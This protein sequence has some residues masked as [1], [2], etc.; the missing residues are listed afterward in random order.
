M[1]RLLFGVL[2]T[3]SLWVLTNIY[4]VKAQTQIV[5]QS[6]IEESKL[7]YTYEGKKIPLKQRNDVVGVVFKQN[8]TQSTSLPLH[9]QLQ[10]DLR[11]NRKLSKVEIKS[12]GRSYALMKVA[13]N[14]KKFA[15]I[16]LRLNQ[17]DYIDT[18]LPVLSRY[19]HREEII[20]PNEI[21]VTFE[22]QL[23]PKQ[24]LVILQQNSLE[25]VRTSRL[26]T[27]RYIVKSKIASGTDIL[28]I[29]NQ[30]YQIKG[31]KSATPNFIQLGNQEISRKTKESVNRFKKKS[32]TEINTAF[33]SNLLPQQWYL[34]STPLKFCLANF[35]ESVD[36]CLT[37]SMYKKSDLS[38]LRTDIY[39]TE[40]WQNSNAGKGV[41]VAVLD[42]LIQWDHP[43]LIKNVYTI[44]K[45]EKSKFN[46]EKHGWDFV[47]DDA[48]TRI[49]Q[50][51]LSKF[52]PLFQDTFW[53][54]DDALLEK[55]R[56]YVLKEN[57]YESFCIRKKIQHFCT[58][59]QIAEKI[60][61]YIRSEIT[62]LFHGTLVSGVIAAKPQESKGLF[63]VAPH[64]KILPVN[65]GKIVY[66]SED[67]FRESIQTSD[68]VEGIDY[69]V[70]R[71][72]DIVN[73]S[74]G[75]FLPTAE[76][77]NAIIRAYN[78]NPSIVFVG[79]AS[80]D[81]HIEVDFPAAIKGVIAVGATNINGYR[82]PYSNFGNGLTVVAPGGDLSME[83]I[84]YRGGI[85]T[86]G[87]TGI[88]KFW[89]T[90][91]FKPKTPW[92]STLDT[93]GKYIRVQ[94]TSFASPIVAGVIAL[95]K[96]EDPQRRLSRQQIISILK[97]T[98]SYEGLNLSEE[99][100]KRYE[101]LVLSSKVPPGISIEKY[102]FGH[103]LVN[104][105]KAVKEVQR[106]LKN[107]DNSNTSD[108]KNSS[109]VDTG[110]E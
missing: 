22:E 13:S 48:D 92:G 86:T 42:F 85:L 10:Q 32:L 97:Q 49:S 56:H 59:K 58:R 3:S 100:K 74:L 91:I 63:G 43:D 62:G 51:A 24:K 26:N 68:V 110:K 71:G 19:K 33:Q 34:N 47:N 37:Q 23:S 94:G 83:K 8:A 77:K 36:K 53:L 107:L 1:K 29:A 73:I 16:Q 103:G 104:A 57:N 5:K 52:R 54:S 72:A 27:N 76:F 95:M 4:P 93:K 11:R 50:K 60:R 66:H 41:V 98:S 99:E 2:F 25:I 45:K 78:K 64:A 39:A 31:V 105:Q 65:V 46:D 70:A 75:W 20:L 67:I 21:I 90:I 80:N 109:T 40:A 55:Y 18:T 106:Q 84:G 15:I 30:L 89:Q 87:G 102:F 88:D 9:L 12:L 17:K 96:G 44:G 14:S 28:N 108:R 69:A 61:T 79:S 82:A 81:N 38:L 101:K 35:A 7:F 6:Q